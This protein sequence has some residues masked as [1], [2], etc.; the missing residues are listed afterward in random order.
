MS[1]NYEATKVATG[2]AT[3]NAIPT[4]GVKR[5]HVCC[6]GCC[7]VRRATIIVN[8]IMLCITLLGLLGVAAAKGVASQAAENA[9]D[10]ETITS[11]QALSDAPVGV[12]VAV[13]LVQSA[14]YV[15]GIFGA[16]KYNS[17]LVLVAFVCYCVTF[18][19]DLFGANIVGMIITACFAYPHFFLHQE[20]RNGVMTPEN[21]I[22]EQQSCCCV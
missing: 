16:I 21:Y 1:D 3:I 4:P 12:L 11:L 20:I 18:A 13:L 8:I 19:F 14:C 22:N 9:D 15:C 5:G 6:G 17:P 7:D 2:E 10:D